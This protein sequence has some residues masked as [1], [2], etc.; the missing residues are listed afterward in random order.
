MFVNTLTLALIYQTCAG[1][2]VDYGVN[3][4]V[5]HVLFTKIM[6]A[7]DFGVEPAWCR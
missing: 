2:G 7:T 1:S 6:Y 5:R 4:S 3:I